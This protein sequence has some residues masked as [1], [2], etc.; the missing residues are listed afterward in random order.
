MGAFT[1]AMGTVW[2]FESDLQ[3][4]YFVNCIFSPFNFFFA[5]WSGKGL[6]ANE[7]GIVDPISGGEVREKM[8]MYKGVGV[9]INDPFESFRKSKS[10]TF[11]NRMRSRDGNT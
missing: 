4:N 1:G 10:Q 11:I 6:G 3:K 8:D 7:Q 5:G 2:E 9:A